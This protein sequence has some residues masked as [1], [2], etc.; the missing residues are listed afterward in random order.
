[1]GRPRGFPRGRLLERGERLGFDADMS[2][3]PRQ[4]L[5]A[6]RATQPHQRKLRSVDRPKSDYFFF[7]GA[8]C[9]VVRG[10]V[11]AYCGFTY[12]PEMAER[13]WPPVDFPPLLDMSTLPAD[14]AQNLTPGRSGIAR[15]ASADSARR[16][17]NGFQRPQQS[18]AYPQACDRLAKPARFA[19]PHSAGT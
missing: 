9:T 2:F 7:G 19:R 12:W 14:Q 1:M 10:C 11:S 3:V 4:A 6:Q 17:P 18:E 13:K 8:S 15:E 16:V 5:R